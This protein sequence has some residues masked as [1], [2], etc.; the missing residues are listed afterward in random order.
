VRLLRREATASRAPVPW[1]ALALLLVLNLAVGGAGWLYSRANAARV[2]EESLEQLE[3]IAGLKQSQLDAWRSERLVDAWAFYEN[4]MISHAVIDL[5]RSPSTPGTRARIEP[6]LEAVSRRTQYT[7]VTILGD[8]AQPLLSYPPTE[9]PLGPAA[10]HAATLLAG[11]KT[12]VLSD[13]IVDAVGEA[14]VLAVAPVLDPDAGHNLGAVV[15]AMDPHASLYPLIANW[16]IPSATAE[17]LLVCNHD[18]RPHYASPLRFRDDGELHGVDLSLGSTL[19]AAMAV[20][21]IQGPVAGTDYRG[22]PVFATIRNVSGLPWYLVVKIDRAEVEAGAHSVSRLVVVALL[23]IALL[24]SSWVLHRWV[25]QAARSRAEHTR[26]RA[27]LDKAREMESVAL[28]AAG[29]AHDFN[30]ILAGIS[31]AA[32]VLHS[33]SAESDSRSQADLILGATRRAA[34]TV[35]G[36]LAFAEQHSLRG[37]PIELAGFVRAEQRALERILGPA[38]KL[39]IEPSPAPAWIRGDGDLLA[40]ALGRLAEHAREAMPAGGDFSIAVENVGAPP[41]PPAAGGAPGGWVRLRAAHGGEG[42]TDEVRR[43][44]FEPFY[45]A[46]GLGAGAG[47][48][49]AAVHGIVRQHGGTIEVEGSPGRGTVFTI[50]LP[51]EP[52]P[53]AAVQDGRARRGA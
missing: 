7:S 28:L 27:R 2:R 13:P 29:V 11:G 46:K 42:M 32:E 45:S 17:A 22:V 16:P 48:G 51:R 25:R 49:L 5:I 20:R 19:I 9:P 47:I 23:V 1:D 18:G 31:G 36:L 50:V 8:A 12:P 33:R 52:A 3:A 30:N 14:V 26:L 43:H 40:D 37:S 39:R 21:G 53:P 15:L 6:V 41:G 10:L 44:V 24:L 4:T 38:V 34:S 35:E